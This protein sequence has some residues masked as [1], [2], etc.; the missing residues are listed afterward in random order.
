MRKIGVDYNTNRDALTFYNDTLNTL[1][2]E[3]T[4]RSEHEIAEFK[5]TLKVKHK[6]H[7]AVLLKDFDKRAPKSSI[8]S[9][10]S[11]V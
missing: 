8:I 2:A 1:K 9:S 7:K 5:S 3:A 6:E 11:A 4:E 10:S